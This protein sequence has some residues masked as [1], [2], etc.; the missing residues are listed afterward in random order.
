MGDTP[1]IPGPN[2]KVPGT[3]WVVC[4]HGKC[5]KRDA[6]HDPLK[7]R[8]VPKPNDEC[9]PDDPDEPHKCHCRAFRWLPD[10]DKW[11]EE[12]QP[13]DDD[14]NIFCFCVR[15]PHGTSHRE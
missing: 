12:K 13:F 14:D 11:K 5:I 6:P 10:D 9:D 2:Q 7:K 4:E 8:C 1:N 3:D 15:K